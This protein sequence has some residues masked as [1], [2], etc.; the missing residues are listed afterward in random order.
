MLSFHVDLGL[1]FCLFH[2]CKYYILFV[3][4]YHFSLLCVAK[5]VPHLYAHQQSFLAMSSGKK[6]YCAME[7]RKHL[8]LIGGLEILMLLYYYIIDR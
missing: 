5:K 3:C 8:D 4:L 7:K 6:N 1:S 2:Q